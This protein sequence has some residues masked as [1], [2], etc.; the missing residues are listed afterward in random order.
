[1]EYTA[2]TMTPKYVEAATMTTQNEATIALKHVAATTTTL[3]HH[4]QLS[5]NITGT[6]ARFFPA[7]SLSIQHEKIWSI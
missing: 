1:M 7:L 3:R 2:V 4:P 6:V 5:D